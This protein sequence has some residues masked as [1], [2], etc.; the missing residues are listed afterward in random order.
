VMLEDREHILDVPGRMPEL[1]GHG[2]QAGMAARKRPSVASSRACAGP[3]WTGTALVT[4]LMPAS[5]DAP[6]G[7]SG[8]NPSVSAPANRYPPCGPSR[9]RMR[10][11]AAAVVQ[12]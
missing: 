6:D 5:R 7:P 8:F 10:R 4:Q 3:N 2:I 12:I 9:T 1:H 11:W